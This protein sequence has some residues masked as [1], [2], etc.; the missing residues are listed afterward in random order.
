MF[1]RRIL[2][3][4][5]I[6]ASRPDRKPLILRGARQVGKTTAIHL[7]SKH[8]DQYIYL[9]L[10]ITGDKQLFE[11]DLTI[12]ELIDAIFFYKKIKKNSGKILL[13]IDEIQN[14]PI[15]VKK[16]RYFYESANY[17]YV[18]AAGSL[19]ETLIERH[20]SFPVGRVEFLHMYPLT[21][22]EYLGALK[23]EQA[24]E[25]LKKIPFPQYAHPHLLKL[26]YN[27]VL[28]GG[29]PEIVKVF[30]ESR[31]ILQLNPIY[32][33]L[34][35]SYLDDVEK[36][37]RTKSFAMVLR[38]VIKSCF[39]EAGKRIKFQG[40]GQSNYR[41]REIKEALR[42]LEKAMLIKLLYPST[43]INFPIIPNF[44]KSPKL[45][46][47]DTGLINYFVGLQTQL[48]GT[49]ELDGVYEGKIAEHIVGQELIALQQSMI[50]NLSFWVREK[51]QSSAEI[52][53]IIPFDNFII[54][55]EVKSGKAGKLKS[56]HY[57]LNLA[58]HPYG[59]RIY[60]GPLQ[61]NTLR[62]SQ[63]KEIKLLNLPFYLVGE[64]KTYLEW[65][66]HSK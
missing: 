56:L 59:V 37:A 61:I 21:F 4:L 44:R 26:F 58:P 30:L 20:L 25:A 52:D 19:L 35:T 9:N 1:N 45:Q 28:L 32:E 5:K 27:Y 12:D 13:F 3:D 48:F 8:F 53:F 39:F 66:I 55:L 6:W 18:I 60:S 43:Q 51:K 31:D 54:P 65:F 57:F 38:H 7:F 11:E 2:N 23:E 63:G 22:E 47:L 14:S 46:V 15:A 64:I 50:Q 62:T 40:F 10:E 16:L 41:S 33:S 17:L 24:L 29:M 36:Y 49:K 42:T 34:L